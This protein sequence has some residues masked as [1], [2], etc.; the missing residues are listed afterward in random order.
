MDQ[1]LIDN[2]ASYLDE[3]ESTRLKE[4][5]NIPVSVRSDVVFE[6]LHGSIAEAAILAE[7]PLEL[8][9][10]LD[11]FDSNNPFTIRRTANILNSK[12]V[13][14]P[15]REDLEYRLKN[16]SQKWGLIVPDDRE[17]QV[18]AMEYGL[19][20]LALE[21]LR[22]MSIFHLQSILYIPASLP[23]PTLLDTILDIHPRIKTDSVV[24]SCNL[25]SVMHSNC[26]NIEG[27]I[28]INRVDIIE[29][30]MKRHSPP[31]NLNNILR[32][33][34]DGTTINYLLERSSEFSPDLDFI[35][36]ILVFDRIT[37][38]YPD[39]TVST[40]A[41]SLMIKLLI[42]N[43]KKLREIENLADSINDHP[44]LL[45]LAATLDLFRVRLLVDL[46]LVTN[47]NGAINNAI[48]FEHREIAVYLEG[49]KERRLF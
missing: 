9:Y 33:L 30:M 36:A 24:Y 39:R 19:A 7:T 42:E 46:G 13:I 20:A 18:I 44:F 4:L 2:I 8:D 5:N 47:L 22:D 49:L 26:N 10:V 41:K 37:L 25:Q 35:K 15:P 6:T 27:A 11:H 3:Y 28:E 45:P 34:N 38:V 14:F 40:N 31:K 17:T 12:G 48:Y 23:D 29:Y 32:V 43:P 16:I 1:L 21:R